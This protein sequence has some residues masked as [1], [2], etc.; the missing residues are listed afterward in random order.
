MISSF[1]YQAK[2]DNVLKRSEVVDSVAVGIVV[3]FTVILTAA[4]SF[5]TD[6][7]ALVIMFVLCFQYE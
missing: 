4:E 5:T 7:I 3:I 6:F 2:N 1:V